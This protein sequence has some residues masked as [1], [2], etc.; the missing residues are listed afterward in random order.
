MNSFNPMS[1]F[2]CCIL[3]VSHGIT[4]Y[5]CFRLCNV[6]TPCYFDFVQ[7]FIWSD[8]VNRQHNRC[9]KVPGN[10]PARLTEIFVK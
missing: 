9:V 2:N 7:N 6:K 10:D 4:T 8:E 5:K 1:M 3:Y